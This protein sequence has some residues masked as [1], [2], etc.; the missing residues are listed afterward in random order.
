MKYRN[1][2]RTEIKVSEIGFG[3]W[4]IGGNWGPQNEADSIAALHKA[5]D[6]G[7]IV[8]VAFDEGVLTGKYTANSTFAAGDFRNTYF[9]GDR[10]KRAVERTERIKDDIKETG[11]TLP[12][13]ALKFALAH[14]AVSTV[15]VGMRNAQ[16]ADADTA[17]SDLPDLSEKMLV[18]LRRHM[19][20][21]GL[22]YAGK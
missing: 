15:V 18:R 4:A 11:R 17:I 6:V 10:L 14:P 19:W 16:Q 8:R 13:V 21:R 5:L 20:R 7:V 12:Q 2:G 9:A 22:W 1:L 3:A